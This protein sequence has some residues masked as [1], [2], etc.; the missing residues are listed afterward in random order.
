MSQVLSFSTTNTQVEHTVSILNRLFP[1]P[2]AFTVRLWN[3]TELPAS[4]RSAFSLILNHPGALRRMFAPPIEL[5]LGEAFIYGDFDIDGDIFSAFTLFDVI[6][7][8]SISASEVVAL[9]RESRATRASALHTPG[10]FG[11]LGNGALPRLQSERQ[12]A[13]R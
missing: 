1:A 11:L 10:E 4:S 13:G 8:R 2:R 3:G 9:A 6:F 7:N 5:A 12:T